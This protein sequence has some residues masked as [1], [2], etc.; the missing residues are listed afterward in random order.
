MCICMLTHFRFFPLTI[1]SYYHHLVIPCT[2]VICAHFLILAET[3]SLLS[4]I[5]GMGS[6]DGR[7]SHGL[8]PCDHRLL[9]YRNLKYISRHLNTIHNFTIHHNINNGVINHILSSNSMLETAPLGTTHN[10]PWPSLIGAS[11]KV[12][13][14]GPYRLLLNLFGI[15]LLTL[16]LSFFL[17]I[18]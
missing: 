12:L 14:C 7:P 18:L 4:W 6:K 10:R 9:R 11:Y 13:I 15:S 3:K 16:I 2:Y 1:P 17:C 5:R 8:P